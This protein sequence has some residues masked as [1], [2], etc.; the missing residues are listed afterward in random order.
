[1]R[2]ATVGVDV[3]GTKIA[4]GLVDADGEVLART[5]LPTP[6]GDAAALLGSIG[7]AVDQVRDARPGTP[8]DAVGVAVAGLVD[9]ERTSVL[10]APNLSGWREEPLARKLATATGL[11]VALEN[12]AN[13]ATWGEARYGAG[14][15]IHQLVCVTVGTGIGGAMVLGGVLHRGRWGVAGEI[16][17]L[18]LQHDGRLCPCGNRGC[19]E[20][21]ASGSALVATARAYAAERPVEASM[22][23]SLAGTV[24]GIEGRHVMHAAREGD[25]VALAAF[26]TCGSWLGRGLA[27]MAAMLD[28]EV[29][30]IGGGVAE[31]G[32]LLLAPARATFAENLLAGSH[33]PHARLVA[34][35]LGSDAGLIGAADLARAMVAKSALERGKRAATPRL[36][37]LPG[38]AESLAGP[39]PRMDR[40][41]AV[42]DRADV[43]AAA[44]GRDE[45]GQDRQG[46]LRR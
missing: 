27:S 21:Y 36:V 1:M 26:E 42:L 23:L 28:P 40:P 7:T 4:A 45:L 6:D 12:D 34:G 46:D 22:L 33:R 3:G 25:P 8:V 16:G 30:V 39:Q 18:Q 35:T 29:F 19:W 10:F 2:A 37:R 20:Q 15:G 43:G 38:G 14:R 5:T 9:V 11:P 13:A 17:H 41:L 44:D 24:E 31:A 32:D